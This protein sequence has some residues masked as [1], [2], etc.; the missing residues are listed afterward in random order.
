MRAVHLSA[1]PRPAL[2][3]DY[4][5]IGDSRAGFGRLD[6]QRETR[7]VDHIGSVSLGP[8]RGGGLD[9]FDTGHE[10]SPLARNRRLAMAASDQVTKG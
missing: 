2:V 7:L 8:R 9:Q 4:R 10:L 6:Y 3:W 5:G 1:T